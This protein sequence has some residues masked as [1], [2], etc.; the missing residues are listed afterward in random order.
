MLAII[1]GATRHLITAYGASLITQGYLDAASLEA[2]TG[3]ALAVIS[4]GWSAWDAKQKD[5]LIKNK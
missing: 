5:K 4:F 3:A 1:L 2:I